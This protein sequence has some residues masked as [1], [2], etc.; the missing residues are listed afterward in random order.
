MS[1]RS[2]TYERNSVVG[3]L[4]RGE[5]D[6]LG[7]VSRWVAQVLT[8]PRF[9][10]L[11]EEWKDLHQEVMRRVLVS[12]RRGHFDPSRDLRA[13]VQG[14]A[15]HTA[16]EAQ[17]RRSEQPIPGGVE[18]WRDESTSDERDAAERRYLARSV[19]DRVSEDC[20]G[21]FQLVFFEGR[22]YEEVA[23]ALDVPVGTVKSRL[24]RCLQA[25]QGL[26]LRRRR[27]APRKELA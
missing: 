4:L 15:R 26:I 18:R 9:W 21:M 24:F 11:R 17:P 22:T 27:R 13:Y 8:A 6:T 1:D 5:P 12:L 20:R 16:F 3:K 19:M 14:V 10:P 25:A 7:L 2:Y 23:A